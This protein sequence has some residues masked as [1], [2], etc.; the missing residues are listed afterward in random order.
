VSFDKNF[1]LVFIENSEKYE[2]EGERHEI[3]DTKAR[4]SEFVFKCKIAS[5]KD[6]LSKS[7]DYLAVQSDASLLTC[8]HAKSENFHLR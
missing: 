6:M 1:S 4:V 2:Y 3:E 7:D 8:A 5:C